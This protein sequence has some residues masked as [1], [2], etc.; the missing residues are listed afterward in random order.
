MMHGDKYSKCNQLLN[1]GDIVFE[2]EYV[3]EYK[4]PV[5]F[6]LQAFSVS[7]SSE[8]SLESKVIVYIKIPK[9]VDYNFLKKVREIKQFNNLSIIELKNKLEG[10]NL[11]QLG[12]SIEAYAF[13]LQ[14][15]CKELG[16]E[17]FY[18]KV[19]H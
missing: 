15:Q 2:S 11:F 4:C 14:S 5:C 7:Y 8:E 13:R 3:I 9:V 12:E 6:Y 17:V 10:K 16:I 18:E 1:E 19:Q